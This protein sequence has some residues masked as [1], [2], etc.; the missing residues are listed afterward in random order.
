MKKIEII[1]AV[2]PMDFGEIE[3]KIS[4]VVGKVKVVQIDICD[5]QFTPVPTWPY[6]KHDDTFEKIKKEEEGMPLWKELNYEF[7][8]MVNNPHEVVEDWVMAGASRIIVHAE[9]RGGVLKAIDMLTGRVDVGLAL[10]IDTSLDIVSQHAE[11]I[12]FVQFM[13]IDNVGFQNEPFDNKVLAKIAECKKLFPDLPVSIDGG[14]SFETAPE[15]IKAGVDRLVSG[16]AIFG[17]DNP[18]EAVDKFK[19]IAYKA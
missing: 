7:D 9:C 14:V 11:K 5:G 10:N 17:S 19:S 2:L 12:N 3:D 4:F 1:P 15:L 6:K 16:S 13:G 18:V 8:L